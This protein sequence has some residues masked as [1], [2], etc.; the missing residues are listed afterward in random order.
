M[1]KFERII[2]VVFIV[3]IYTGILD[4]PLAVARGWMFE[5][6]DWLTLPFDFVISLII[7]G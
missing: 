6:L 4:A 5:I 1:M 2:F 3:V 7:G